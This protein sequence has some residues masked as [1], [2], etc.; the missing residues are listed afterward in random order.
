MKYNTAMVVAKKTSNAKMINFVVLNVGT[1][2]SNDYVVKMRNMVKRNCSLGHQFHVFTD[3]SF[4][5]DDCIVHRV[6]ELPVEK[7]D[8]KGW[9][10]KIYLFN[11]DNGL[12]GTVFYLDLDCVII[13]NIDH[14]IEQGDHFYICQDFNRHRSPNIKLLN[15]SVMQWTPNNNTHRIWQQWIDNSK[16]Y[17]NDH[18]GDQDY[19]ARDCSWIDFK[20]N[21]KHAI[22][23]YKW[24]A[25]NNLHNRLSDMNLTPKITPEHR[26]YVF[27]GKPDPH[28]INDLVISNNWR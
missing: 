26:I 28:D 18:R 13:G 2:Y 8:L 23:S 9:W 3:K 25:C 22:V 5:Y 21:N 12:S 19:L 20:Y 17:I 14:L 10:Y 6:P 4:E 7:T 1:K 27:H 24:E 16:K 15:S 11:L